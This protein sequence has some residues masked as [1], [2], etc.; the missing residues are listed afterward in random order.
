[1]CEIN[2][3][4]PPIGKTEMLI[5]EYLATHKDSLI[6][7]IKAGINKQYKVVHESTLRLVEKGLV[8]LGA[9]I[10][11]EKSYKL[12]FN[13]ICFIMAYSEKIELV[14]KVA[15]NY[16]TDFQ[17]HQEYVTFLE[18]EKKLNPKFLFKIKR[19]TG[20][21]ALDNG[22]EALNPETQLACAMAELYKHNFTNSELR[23][24]K[25]AGREIP[26]VHNGLV[27]IAKNLN[28]YLEG[29]E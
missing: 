5:L 14:N 26:K 22:L 20:K 13:G 9:P 17:D 2:Y 27:R 19:I 23:E 1:M 28:S 3:G 8:E 18:I 12:S 7:P 4:K 10:K 25:R 21:S 24:I 11:N 29:G 15:R 6:S 16:E